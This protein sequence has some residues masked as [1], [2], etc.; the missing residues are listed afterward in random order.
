MIRICYV[1]CDARGRELRDWNKYT[2]YRRKVIEISLFG[3]SLCLPLGKPK[4]HPVNW[5][6]FLKKD[7]P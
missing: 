6:K 7:K 2:L 3:H 4:W 5:D 1:L